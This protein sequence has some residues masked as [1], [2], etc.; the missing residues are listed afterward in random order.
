MYN[1]LCLILKL[2]RIF[3][4]NLPYFFVNF[5]FS[6]LPF[7]VHLPVFKKRKLNFRLVLKYRSPASLT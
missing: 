2:L 7:L 1:I 5:N 6:S 4:I 3:Q